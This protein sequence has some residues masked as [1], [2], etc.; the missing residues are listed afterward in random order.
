MLCNFAEKEKVYLHDDKRALWNQSP[1][2][3]PYFRM[4]TA[5]DSALALSRIPVSCQNTDDYIIC[6]TN[7]LA[8]ESGW[9]D[10]VRKASS[11]ILGDEWSDSGSRQLPVVKPWGFYLLNIMAEE[12]NHPPWLR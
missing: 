11:V 8:R 1:Q 2:P 3:Y 5:G 7:R 6:E 12:I 10:N 4:V 9:K